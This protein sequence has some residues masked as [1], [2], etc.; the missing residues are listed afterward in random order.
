MKR[1][2]GALREVPHY[3]MALFVEGE[4]EEEPLDDAK[5]LMSVEKVLLKRV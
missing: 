2:I 5:R 1:A 3:A 4:G